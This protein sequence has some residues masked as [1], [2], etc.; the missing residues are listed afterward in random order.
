MQKHLMY[1]RLIN[2]PNEWTSFLC[3]AS[4]CKLYWESY[5]IN[6]YR[7]DAFDILQTPREKN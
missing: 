3:C 6:E 7:F 1:I 2:N 4:F 5:K